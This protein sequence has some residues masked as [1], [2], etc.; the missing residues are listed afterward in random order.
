MAFGLPLRPSVGFQ[1]N[2]SLA[3]A[4]SPFREFD[5][6][7]YWRG[8]GSNEVLLEWVPSG[9]ESLVVDGTEYFTGLLGAWVRRCPDIP[10]P[11]I[12]NRSLLV[13]P[14]PPWVGPVATA[15]FV[16]TTPEAG[17]LPC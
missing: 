3:R 10:M 2:C 17:R 11:F 9:V 5:F 1:D 6:A 16:L 7:S 8:G 13:R 4:E 15:R 12:V 14:K